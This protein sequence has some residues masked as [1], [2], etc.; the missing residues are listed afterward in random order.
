MI[1][2]LLETRIRPAVQDD[3]GDILCVHSANV[4]NPWLMLRGE[5]CRCVGLGC[6][7]GVWELLWV[8]KQTW[9]KQKVVVSAV[10]FCACA[11]AP[12]CVLSRCRYLPWFVTHGCCAVAQSRRE[13]VE[14]AR[15]VKR[16]VAGTGELGVLARAAAPAAAAAAAAPVA[17]AG[18]AV[19][20]ACQHVYL[21][22]VARRS[23]GWLTCI[24]RYIG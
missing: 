11:S 14:V 20:C 19:V 2:E 6:G 13:L 5:F 21:L 15:L 7:C 17:A 3:G 10:P 12:S 4:G 8:A 22:A 18:S 24:D 23:C 16:W 9:C 1:K